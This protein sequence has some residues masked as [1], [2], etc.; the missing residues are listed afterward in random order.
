MHIKKVL[1]FCQ[2]VSCGAVPC[3]SA[4]GFPVGGIATVE[5]RRQTICRLRDLLQREKAERRG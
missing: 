4:K 3:P 2:C 5:Q 1:F